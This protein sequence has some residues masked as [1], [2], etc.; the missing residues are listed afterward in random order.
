MV[1]LTAE[2][3]FVLALSIAFFIAGARKLVNQS[4]V[5]KTREHWKFMIVEK[6]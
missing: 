4:S 6:Y 2:L 1:G 3:R 5:L